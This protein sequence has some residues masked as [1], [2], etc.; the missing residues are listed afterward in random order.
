MII[1][2]TL[3]A[4][5][6]EILN[7]NPNNNRANII[8]ISKNITIIMLIPNILI[9][10]NFLWEKKV[11]YILFHNQVKKKVGVKFNY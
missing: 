7:N 8:S 11:K 6:P 1:N 3:N 5:S 9:W 4:N 10:D 2:T